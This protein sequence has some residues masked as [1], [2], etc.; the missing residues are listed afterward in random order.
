[1]QRSQ[2]LQRLLVVWWAALVCSQFAAGDTVLLDED[3]RP[4][5]TSIRNAVL[6]AVALQPDGKVLL[7]G[8]FALV[9]GVARPNLARLDPDG[10]LDPGF[11]P[12]G[13]L[14]GLVFRLA[15]QPETGAVL[16]AGQFNAVAGQPCA[17]LARLHP[18]GTLD[19]GF[20]PQISG[21]DGWFIGAMAIQP[22]GRIVIGG[23]FDQ[24]AGQ[25]R[26]GLARLS[27]D[28][29]LDPTFD[30]GAGLNG[31]TAYDLAVQADGQV[32]VAGVFTRVGEM[33]QA[34][35]ARLGPDGGTDPTFATDVLAGPLAGAVY[36]I[37]LQPDEK[38]VIAGA[39]DTVDAEPRFGIARLQADGRLDASFDSG[40]GIVGD[41]TAVHDLTLLPDGG[42]A[43]TG[44]FTAVGEAVR[45]G[46]AVLTTNG[47]PKIEFDP[48]PGLAPAGSAFGNMLAVQSD[49]QIIAVGQFTQAGDA[50]RHCLARFLPDGSVDPAFSTTNSFL[51]FAGEVRAVA[52]LP[53]GGLLVGGDFDRV[54][55]EWHRGLVRLAADG[56]LDPGF[57][58][59]LTGAATIDAIAVQPDGKP[60]IGGAFDSAGAAPCSNLARLQSDGAFDATFGDAQ[61]DAAVHALALLP[62]GSLLAGGDFALVSG[63]RRFCLV[64]LST[65][66]E[67]DPD[68]DARFE[69]PLDRPTIRA[70]AVDLNGRIVAGGY[71]DQVNGKPRAHLARLNADGTLDSA[72]A[73]GLDLS[74]PPPVVS[75]V[76]PGPDSTVLVGGSFTQV[77][78]VPQAGLLRLLGDGSFDP[79]FA[80]GNTLDGPDDSAVR[81]L[82][83]LSSGA[84]AV[85]GAFQTFAGQSADNFRLLA[86]D[87][88]T[89]PGATTSAGADGPVS[90]VCAIEPDRLIVGGS[91][92][93]F[94]GEARLGLSRLQVKPPEPPYR[95]TIS[96]ETGEVTIRWEGGG[97]LFQSDHASGPWREIVGAT[98]PYE[99]HTSDAARFYRCVK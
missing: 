2:R 1:M 4:A 76:V 30:P 63:T 68:F 97:R 22:D 99:T 80:A 78:G 58:A 43:I 95:M 6:F 54:N 77:A 23:N 94:A 45:S 17:S 29:A 44:S 75:S 42:V 46:I 79:T 8:D 87:G 83:G 10:S 50:A 32:I 31:G 12:T 37:A 93:R 84:L 24:V 59:G 61:P 90:V 91:F 74:G 15:V 14:S 28:G 53:G 86:A 40:A 72:F 69:M 96:R 36:A 47:L 20:H 34:G 67:V 9:N 39:F 81:T 27:A 66:G 35:V 88:S 82:A 57:D 98:S 71:F 64:R 19:V 52:S 49:G 85:G 3:F 41:G 18:D 33:D 65:N 11:D 51:E 89:A 7:A 73:A 16:A 48:G 26:N 62:D 55:G 25:P 92:T 13:G 38:I 5:F 21:P 70:L 56:S 60:I